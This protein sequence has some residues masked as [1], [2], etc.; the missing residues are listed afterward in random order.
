M[1]NSPVEDVPTEVL[2]PLLLC[3]WRNITSY[4]H[5]HNRLSLILVDGE[6][7]SPPEHRNGLQTVCKN[8]RKRRRS[9]FWSGAPNFMNIQ[10]LAGEAPTALL[11]TASAW[12]GRNVTNTTVWVLSHHRSAAVRQRLHVEDG[13]I[14]R[15]AGWNQDG[16][17]G[18]VWL[19][20]LNK[21][22][23][24]WTKLKISSHIFVQFLV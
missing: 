12:G 6:Q 15:S 10:R 7:P 23:W 5:R 22:R 3:F 18:L 21:L 1:G 9:Q 11:L 14:S 2:K 20:W 17:A 13:R 24:I 19:L 16:L 8:S 4:H